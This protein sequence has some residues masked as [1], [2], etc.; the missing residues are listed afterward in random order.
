MIAHLFKI[1][2]FALVMCADITITHVHMKKYRTLKP[3]DF[4]KDEHNPIIRWFY[5]RFTMPVAFTLTLI[6]TVPWL[7]VLYYLF[8]RNY[9]LFFIAGFVYLIAFVLHFVMARHISKEI[10]YRIVLKELDIDHL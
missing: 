6:Y 9:L 4:Y 5:S 2:A 3:N 7:V 1:T 10:S 8:N